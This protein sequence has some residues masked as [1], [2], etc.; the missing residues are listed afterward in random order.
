MGLRPGRTHRKVKRPWTRTARRKAKRAYVKGVPD[1]KI[2]V[3]EMGN[4]K[5]NEWEIE[6]NLISESKCQMRDN[7]L[8]S[9]RVMANKI[10]ENKITKENYFFK[11]RVYPHQALREHAIVMG[12]GA[13][14]ISKGMK[15]AYGKPVGRAAVVKKGQK[16]MS[17]WTKGKFEKLARQGMYR[18]GIKL[19]AKCKVEVIDLMK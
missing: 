1:S 13:D 12:A 4:V 8:E 9:A 2:R 7:A 15:K 18:A 5:G 3:F 6:V 16:I 14:R 10:F 11:I 17:V 19:P